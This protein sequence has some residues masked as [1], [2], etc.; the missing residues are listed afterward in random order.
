MSGIR[1]SRRLTGTVGLLVIAAGF[2]GVAAY[3][4]SQGLDRATEWLS[5]AGGAAAVAVGAEKPAQRLL[6]WRRHGGV[7]A[8]V[9]VTDAAEQLAMALGEEWRQWQTWRTETNPEVLRVRW[10]VTPD[11]ELAM[12]GVDWDDVGTSSVTVTPAQLATEGDSLYQT[13]SEQLPHRR[14][15]ML[16]PAGAGKSALARQLAQDLLERRPAE[17]RVPVFLSL[18]SWNPE[19]RLYD[20]VA[21]KLSRD[22]PVLAELAAGPLGRAPASLA[23][24]LVDS[25]RLILILDGFDEIP[26]P[27][28]ERALD[29]IHGLGD[30]VPL[31]LTSRPAEYVKAVQDMGRGLSRAGAVE[32]VPVNTQAIKRY[33]ARTTAAVPAGRWDPVFALLDQGSHNP[34]ALVLRTPLMIWLAYV[35]YRDK[36]SVPAELA[37]NRRFADTTAVERHLLNSMVTAVYMS[38]GPVSRSWSPDRALRW[39]AFL[40]RWLERMQTYDLAWWDLPKALHRGAGRLVPGVPVGLAAGVPTVIIVGELDG[41]PIGLASGAVFTVLAT[42]R[43]FSRAVR[44]PAWRVSGPALGRATVLVVGLVVGLP[45][46]FGGNLATGLAHG[47]VGGMLAGLAAGFIIDEGRTQPT[48]VRM[49]IRGTWTQFLQRLGLGLLLGLAF[50]VV[51]GATLGVLD[52][53]A[54]GLAY[55]CLSL[56]MGLAFGIEDGLLLWLD[57]PAELMSPSSPRM[58]RSDDRSAALERALVAGPFAGLVAGLSVTFA[59]GLAAGIEV[60]LAM[61]VAVAVTDRAVGVAS[62]CWGTFTLARAWLALRGDLPWRLMTFLEDA[63]ELGVL[64]RSGTV[65]QFRHTRLQQRLAL[66]RTQP[67]PG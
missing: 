42:A 17:G 54:V 22:H 35:V 8:K 32:L 3:L 47:V 67:L 65:H 19:E 49:R 14:L 27:S 56:G 33:L 7:P 53:P 16:G 1:R 62:S 6:A 24:L 52:N 43:A 48:Q 39:L 4:Y 29:R 40:A 36:A 30:R 57:A 66:R 23:R 21:A 41:L 13:Y 63:Y 60:A 2:I 12:T 31:V 20:W 34:V 9:Q 10:T 28:R 61:A 38:S 64:R 44:R 18:A 46:A 51:L 59:Y 5:L 26:E 58:V 55:G 11:A 50:G 45:F 37:D 25:D 15:I